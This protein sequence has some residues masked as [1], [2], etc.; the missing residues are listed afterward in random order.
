MLS[1]VGHICAPRQRPPSV[2]LAPVFDAILKKAYS[3]G[4]AAYGAL[5]LYDGQYFRAGRGPWLS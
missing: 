3:L 4:G 1:G 2:V 5:A